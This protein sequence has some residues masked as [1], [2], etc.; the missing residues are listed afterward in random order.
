MLPYY[1]SP[2]DLRPAEALGQ[3]RHR[4]FATFHRLDIPNPQLGGTKNHPT[5]F[6]PPYHR[7]TLWKPRKLAANAAPRYAAFLTN[8]ELLSEALQSL[9][10]PAAETA[11]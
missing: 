7:P 3:P 5:R 11:H 1:L 4:G 2:H 6:T 9:H 10:L 8:D